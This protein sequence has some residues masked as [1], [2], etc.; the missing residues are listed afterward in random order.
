[1]L[2]CSPVAPLFC[3]TVGGVW[4]WAGGDATRVTVPAR[5]AAHRVTRARMAVRDSRLREDMGRLRWLVT[6]GMAATAVAH[7]ELIVTRGAVRYGRFRY[8]L[9][10]RDGLR[11]VLTSRPVPG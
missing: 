7:R 1:M 8:S 11:C 2:S 4:A 6:I 9:G 10:R 5:T 3:E